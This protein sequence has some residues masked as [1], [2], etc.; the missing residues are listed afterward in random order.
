V[1]YNLTAGGFG[2]L[3]YDAPARVREKWSARQRG[4]KNHNYGKKHPE[5]VKAKISATLQGREITPEAR[6]K[7]S[8]K[9]KGKKKSPEQIAKMKEIRGE[10]HYF[11]GKHHT[12]ET[13]AKL[14]AIKKEY[15]K[16]PEGQENL[17]KLHAKSGKYV[18]KTPG[19]MKG[20][21]HTE[22]ARRNM[23][24][25]KLGKKHTPEQLAKRKRGSA[26]RGENHHMYG[27][28]LSLE[29]REKLS[30][31]QKKR[32][33]ENPRPKG[34]DHWNYG[35]KQSPENIEKIRATHTG[36]V[37]SEETR[38]KISATL[39]RKNQEKQQNFP[40]PETNNT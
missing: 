13:K 37:V 14:R 8:S 30:I 25:S 1:G 36:K 6:E 33:Q 10:K 28:K 11:Y 4:E 40:P 35:R 9:L 17:K 15:V 32:L 16:T 3:G 18:R 39:K 19:H 22:E 31:A 34:K 24:L 29:Q 7:I 2:S 38:A 26:G 12:P 5:E 23:S 21:K 27:K 20:R